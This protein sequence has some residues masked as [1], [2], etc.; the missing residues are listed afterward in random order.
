MNLKKRSQK[1]LVSKVLAILFAG[2]TFCAGVF[3]FIS[4][5][6]KASAEGEM[7]TYPPSMNDVK[8]FNPYEG[9]IVAHRISR[10]NFVSETIPGK[11]YCDHNNFYT[12]SEQV[13]RNS[14]WVFS[15]YLEYDDTSS[16]YISRSNTWNTT[17]PTSDGSRSYALYHFFCIAFF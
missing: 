2:A 15:N 16:Y 17:I 5:S 10:N 9:A 14:S 11:F 7:I 3:P 12:Y 8:F 13:Y 6:Y 4:K 1:K